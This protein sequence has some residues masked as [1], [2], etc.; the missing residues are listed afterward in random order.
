MANLTS[1]EFADYIRSRIDISRTFSLDY[2]N[3]AYDLSMI[4]VVENGTA[5]LSILAPDDTAV[6]ATT[7][8]NNM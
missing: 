1:I 7:S 3:P 2:Y 6:A 5:H 8:I 4:D